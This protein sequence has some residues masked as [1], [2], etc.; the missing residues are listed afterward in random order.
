MAHYESFLI[1][2]PQ[3]V[4]GVDGPPGPKGNMVHTQLPVSKQIT[5]CLRQP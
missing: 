5:M 4:A 1:C 2:R 3:G